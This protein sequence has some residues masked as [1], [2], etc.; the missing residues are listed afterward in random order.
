MP[1]FEIILKFKSEGLQSMG[2]FWKRW[3][4]GEKITD[5]I[6]IRTRN[7][8]TKKRK[9]ISFGYW[10]AI[11]V[12]SILCDTLYKAMLL[13]NERKLSDNSCQWGSI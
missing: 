7:W 3:K 5:H 10:T 1:I 9:T 13:N 4:Q 11:H 6:P 12:C 8:D 2:D